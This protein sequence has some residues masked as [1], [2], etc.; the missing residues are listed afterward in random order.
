[1]DDDAFDALALALTP[2]AS[3]RGMLSSLMSILLT[4]LT[5]ASGADAAAKNKRKR[6]R[7]RKKRKHKNSESLLPPPPP[8][9]LLPPPPPA[10]VGSCT[11]KKCGDDGCG[12]SCGTCSG[13]A[14]CE[15]GQCRCPNGRDRCDGRCCNRGQICVAGNCLTGQGTCAPGD[16]SCIT[17]S[18]PCDQNASCVCFQS[19]EGETR[20]GQPRVPETVCGNCAN[21]ATCAAAFPGTPGIFCAFDTVGPTGCGC[22]TGQGACVPPCST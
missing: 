19:T 21:S 6:R 20:C 1:M 2:G 14:V 10:C 22:A 4:A 5:L 16:D 11:G 12:V 18:I 8:P 9:P 13:G 3:R 17:E 7:K 15:D